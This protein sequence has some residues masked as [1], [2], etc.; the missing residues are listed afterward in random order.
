MAPAT[1]PPRHTRDAVCILLTFAKATWVFLGMRLPVSASVW[2][3]GQDHLA[4]SHSRG[5]ASPGLGLALA[6]HVVLRSHLR[7]R[8]CRPLCQL[9]LYLEHGGMISPQCLHLKHGDGESPCPRG[10]GAGWWV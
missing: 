7:P 9:V 5:H 10:C 2:W 4:T 3:L 1:L 8:V 6:S